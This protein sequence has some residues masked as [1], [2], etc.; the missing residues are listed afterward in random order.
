MSALKDVKR[1]FSERSLDSLSHSIFMFYVITA[2]TT[3]RDDEEG[4]EVAILQT[5][6]AVSS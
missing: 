6:I 4:I 5:A 2:L 1:H 3:A